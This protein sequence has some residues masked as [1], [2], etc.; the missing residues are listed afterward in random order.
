[1]T[2]KMQRATK[3][4]RIRRG[5]VRRRSAAAVLS[6]S[7][8]FAGMTPVCAQANVLDDAKELL[9]DLG[10]KI[11]TFLDDIG[12]GEVLKEGYNTAADFVFTYETQPDDAEME[13]LARTWAITA[14]L[15]DEEKGETNTYYF[16]NHTL[17]MVKDLTQIGRGYNLNKTPD[18]STLNGKHTGVLKATVANATDYTVA[19]AN[20]DDELSLYMAKLMKEKQ[21]ADAAAAETEA[22]GAQ[23]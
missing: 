7:L 1:M 14:W 16:D 6:L 3:M 21:D 13:G 2:T 19:W 20:Y 10:H 4:N 22:A 11:G 15:A 17:T 5:S 23:P 12:V 18:G 8:L 9:S